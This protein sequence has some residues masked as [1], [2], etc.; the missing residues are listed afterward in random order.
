MFVA[1][2][3]RAQQSTPVYFTVHSLDISGAVRSDAS[4]I[5][6]IL[7]REGIAAGAVV[8][9]EQ[10]EASVQG[11]K[12]LQLF[13]EV[14]FALED[15]P[16]ASAPS[17]EGAKVLRL[18]V[19]DRWTLIPIAKFSS[20]G[21]ASQLILGAYDA[22]LSGEVVE[23]GAQYE[24][25][26]STNSGVGW[27]KNPRLF[28]GRVSLDLQAW[29]ISRLRTRYDQKILDEEA[30]YGFLHV[31]EKY[32][33]AVN[34]ELNTRVEWGLTLEAN[35]DHFSERYLSDEL[36]IKTASEGGIPARTKYLLAGGRMRFG[37]VNHDN[38]RVKGWD[39]ELTARHGSA[40]SADEKDFINSDLRIRSFF[41][42]IAEHT[43]AWRGMLGATSAVSA[44]YQY[45]FGGLSEIRGFAD[46]RFT[47]SKYWLSNLEYR[48][49]FY[50]SRDL[51]LQQVTFFDAIGISDR[52]VDLATASG[53]SAGV[54][55][56]FIAPRIYRFVARFDYAHAMVRR[57]P[58]P[59]SFGV[60][61]FF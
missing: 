22:N 53:A 18:F 29:N 23:A 26:G 6:E 47:G 20:G 21:G 35:S 32:Y 30:R 8:S 4:R 49:P 28:G 42:P 17:V 1:T 48:V 10:V 38:W 46:G 44:Q 36:L 56:R 50:S 5:G 45:D 2:G 11:L 3:L 41:N 59:V 19:R 40:R 31:R 16:P 58:L 37:V 25:L 57:S 54:G 13:S 24:R 55:V 33:L 60:Q 39:A 14:E 43:L 34:R 27:F 61:Q 12:N 15:P 51:V 52:E 9:Q 7:E